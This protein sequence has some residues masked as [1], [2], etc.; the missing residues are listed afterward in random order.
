MEPQPFPPATATGSFVPP[1]VEWGG[2]CGLPGEE[3][4]SK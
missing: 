3:V 2:G 1:D 4:F